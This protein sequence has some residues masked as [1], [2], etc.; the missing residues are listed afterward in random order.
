MCTSIAWV[1]VFKWS[2]GDLYQNIKKIAAFMQP[3]DIELEKGVRVH[4]VSK[5]KGRN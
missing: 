1:I 5:E 2:E 4:M 3:I